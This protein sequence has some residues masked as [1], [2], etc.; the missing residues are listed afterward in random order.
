M[1]G[2]TPCQV[3]GVMTRPRSPRAS[4]FGQ[5]RA[6]TPS[7]GCSRTAPGRVPAPPRRVLV[8]GMSRYFR[9]RPPDPQS[10]HGGVTCLAETPGDAAADS[11]DSLSCRWA[12]SWRRGPRPG[13]SR[14]R[15]PNPPRPQRFRRPCPYR[16]RP[17]SRPRQRLRRG[18]RRRRPRRSPEAARRHGRRRRDLGGRQRVRRRP[19]DAVP[20]E[21]S[22]R[23]T[24]TRPL[25]LVA[26]SPARACGSRRCGRRPWPRTRE[27]W[28]TTSRVRSQTTTKAWP[29]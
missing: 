12:F 24:S 6:W 27:R 5:F 21:R 9:A 20:W 14:R 28:W 4:V 25:L 3:C 7:A 18:L 13:G 16:S 23:P 11:R 1:S 15:R 8:G 2:S 19:Q 22:S 26:R 17:R 10:T 29:P